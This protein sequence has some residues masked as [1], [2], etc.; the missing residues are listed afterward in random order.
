MGYYCMVDEGGITHVFPALDFGRRCACGRKVLRVTDDRTV[1]LR[2]APTRE[3]LSAL[4]LFQA[5]A[6]KSGL[7]RSIWETRLFC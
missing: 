2:D 5:A 6:R 7:A 4:V 3:R 1:V